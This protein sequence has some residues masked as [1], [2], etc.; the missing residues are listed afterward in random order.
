MKITVWTWKDERWS[1]SKKD[2]QTINEL[3]RKEKKIKNWNGDKF[4]YVLGWIALS[5]FV[6]KEYIIRGA[7][8]CVKKIKRKN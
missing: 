6:L 1:A 7:K 4:F 8:W 2:L 5:P 3:I